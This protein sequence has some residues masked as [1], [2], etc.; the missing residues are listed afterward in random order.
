MAASLGG[1]DAL[2]FT[3]TIGERSDDVRRRVVQK[4]GYLGFTID[5]EKNTGDMN[6]RQCNIAAVGSKPIYVI[7][8]DESDEMIVRANDLLNKI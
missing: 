3:A 5:E 7:K 2:V 8:T 1:V 6:E 4:L